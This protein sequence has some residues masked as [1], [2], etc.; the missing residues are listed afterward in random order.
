MYFERKIS[1]VSKA[2][3]FLR[4]GEMTVCEQCRAFTANN[5][6]N[7]SHARP[8]ILLVVSWTRPLF[9]SIVLKIER[10]TEYLQYSNKQFTA[11]STIHI[12][13]YMQ[14]IEL[15]PISETRLCKQSFAIM[16]QLILD[17]VYYINCVAREF[18]IILITWYT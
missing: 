3:S 17:Q 13:S 1:Y 8:S 5:A 7:T 10:Q 16:S 9:G 11:C 4:F 2:L 12:N 18:A 6:A 14:I 15:Q